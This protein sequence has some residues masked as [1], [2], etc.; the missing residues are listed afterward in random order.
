MEPDTKS[1]TVS[2]T[3]RAET[4]SR[5]GPLSKPLKAFASVKLTIKYEKTAESAN[6]AVDLRD[7]HNNAICG[8]FNVPRFWGDNPTPWREFK[9][10]N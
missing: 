2:L 1:N 10:A 5:A 3:S 7:P 4:P 9:R 6:A 8:S